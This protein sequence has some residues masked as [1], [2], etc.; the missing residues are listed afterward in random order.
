MEPKVLGAAFNNSYTSRVSPLIE[1]NSGVFLLKVNN[2]Q[3]KPADT[4]E[5]A[6]KPGKN[7]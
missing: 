1:G 6:G 7:P 3:L 2:L 4:P 5:N